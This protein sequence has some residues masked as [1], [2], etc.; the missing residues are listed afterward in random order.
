MTLHQ[1]D[2]LRQYTK[3]DKGDG[4]RTNAVPLDWYKCV[5]FYNNLHRFTRLVCAVGLFPKL[6][7]VLARRFVPSISIFRKALEGDTKARKKAKALLVTITKD[8]FLNLQRKQ[9]GIYVRKVHMQEF[10]QEKTLL[11]PLLVYNWVYFVNAADLS[12]L[13]WKNGYMIVISK[14]KEIGDAKRM[15]PCFKK[16]PGADNETPA[17]LR[18]YNSLCPGLPT[19]N[20]NEAPLVFEFLPYLVLQ[21]NI[22]NLGS[23]DEVW[24]RRCEFA[25]SS[26]I[27]LVHIE[28]APVE[29]KKETKPKTPRTTKRKE[30]STKKDDKD[31]EANEQAATKKPKLTTS[32]T[33]TPKKLNESQLRVLTRINEMEFPPEK[34]WIQ[35]NKQWEWTGGENATE[36]E[37]A[38]EL[39]YDMQRRRKLLSLVH[40]KNIISKPTPHHW[41]NMAQQSQAQHMLNKDELV[42]KI[43]TIMTIDLPQL[44]GSE[45]DVNNRYNQAVES[46]N[47]ENY[48]NHLPKWNIDDTEIPLST[49]PIEDLQQQPRQNMSV[50][51]VVTTCTPIDTQGQRIMD[52][53]IFDRYQNI[54]GKIVIPKDLRRFLAEPTN[55]AFREYF[56]RS[57]DNECKTQIRDELRHKLDGIINHIKDQ[58]GIIDRINYDMRNN[59]ATCAVSLLEA[60][61]KMLAYTVRGLVNGFGLPEE[62][63]QPLDKSNRTEQKPVKFSESE[64]VRNL[65]QPG[66]TNKHIAVQLTNSRGIRHIKTYDIKW[67]YEVMGWS[68]LNDA[69][70]SAINTVDY[71]STVLCFAYNGGDQTLPLLQQ[72]YLAYPDAHDKEFTTICKLLKECQEKGWIISLDRRTVKQ[73]DTLIFMI[74][75]SMYKHVQHTTKIMEDQFL[76]LKGNE[77]NLDKWI[78]KTADSSDG[79]SNEGSDNDSDNSHNKKQTP[80]QKESMDRVATA[81]SDNYTTPKASDRY[82]KFASFGPSTNTTASSHGSEDRKS[83]DG[84]YVQKGAGPIDVNT[85]TRTST[86]RRVSPNRYR[87]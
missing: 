76:N 61:T 83:V 27:P 63:V 29:N 6:D 10:L 77:E 9:I 48:K 4:Y 86:R 8:E 25:K 5:V 68:S 57:I 62:I 82:S 46:F 16:D 80:E 72:S 85:P 49:E 74:W 81:V 71:S 35:P 65:Q 24:R 67:L 18:D 36:D 53:L 19:L 21:T 3:K 45:D 58:Y 44:D 70:N 64:E 37:K 26:M 23:D 50:A 13:L 15:A 33:K 28:Q 52:K 30:T 54:C 14:K 17:A 73:G 32:A 42:K 20:S 12:E 34:D 66:I 56:E 31:D 51:R 84:D 79:Q 2:N 38:K 59:N 41:I 43:S 47:L 39:L 22:R 1:Y 55:Y 69:L 7:D 78:N 11:L 87:G 75:E 60:K 40:L